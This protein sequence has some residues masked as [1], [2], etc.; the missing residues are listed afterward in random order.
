MTESSYVKMNFFLENCCNP[1]ILKEIV[2]R[3]FMVGLPGYK[4]SGV[5]LREF[6]SIGHRLKWSSHQ[7]LR[8]DGREQ[9]P[10]LAHQQDGKG[11]APDLNQYRLVTSKKDS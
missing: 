2:A 7:P 1:L 6:A 9:F 8:P 3:L 5:S 11:R 4:K 10:P